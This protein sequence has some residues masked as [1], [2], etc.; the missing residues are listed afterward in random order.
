MT[1]TAIISGI[2]LLLLSDQAQPFDQ[3]PQRSL[4]EAL[5]EPK[6]EDLPVLV[7]ALTGRAC[8]P[9]VTNVGRAILEIGKPAVGPLVRRLKSSTKLS[10]QV[11]CVFLLAHMAEDAEEVVDDLEE[12][13]KEKRYLPARRYAEFVIA[14]VDG[15]IDGLLDLM[16]HAP[17]V[18]RSRLGDM[19]SKRADELS[20]NQLA[21]LRGM[22]RSRYGSAAKTIL[23]AHARLIE[24]RQKQTDSTVVVTTD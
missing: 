13:L 10:T 11:Q 4:A 15:E 20:E 24:A 21:R 14:A 17:S 5:K 7:E 2:C 12:W 6:P 19:L 18:V 23:E 9:K 16:P 1:R 3:T 22:S 8:R